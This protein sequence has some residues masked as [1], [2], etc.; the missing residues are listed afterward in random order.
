MSGEGNY[1][2][3]LLDA[4]DLNELTRTSGLVRSILDSDLAAIERMRTLEHE[5]SASVG[6]LEELQDQEVEEQRAAEEE[7]NRVAAL[8]EERQD[9]R[10]AVAVERERQEEVLAE[11]E[12]DKE[13]Y[14]R[15]VGEL[16][17]QSQALEAELAQLADE[18]EDLQAERRAEIE[19]REQERREQ[20][21]REQAE[22]EQAER[23]QAEREAASDG[24][25]NDDAGSG[26]GG[27]SSDSPGS[28][29]SDSSA[30]SGADGG[31]GLLARPVG[32][33]VTSSFGYRTHPVLGTQRLH[34]GIDFG[35]PTGTPIRAADGGRVVQ[36]GGRGGY[37]I[38]VVIDHGGG[39]STLYAHQSSLNVSAGESVSRGDVIG[40]VGSTG[41][42]TGPHLHFEV[43]E[44]GSPVNPAPYL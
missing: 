43:R 1:A 6:H 9:V 28:G 44:G 17:G 27:G 5:I 41:V 14:D 37:G 15:L 32:G 34:A 7:R 26:S 36:A 39:L 19:R 23:E 30:S 35:A 4:Q 24:S 21:R 42:S 12:A 31:G 40:Y 3:A 11:L 13:E 20:E 29:G 25:G 18:Q 2:D 16:E 8:R 10:D 38:T 33:P 22:R